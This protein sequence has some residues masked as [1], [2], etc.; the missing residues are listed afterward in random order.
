MGE[1]GDEN[2]LW[3]VTA[4][5]VQAVEGG[6]SGRWLHQTLLTVRARALAAKI[7]ASTG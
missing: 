5:A 6:D 2:R 1:N 3:K 4:G 7:K